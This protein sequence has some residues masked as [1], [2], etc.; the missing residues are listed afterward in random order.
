M[1]GC[2]VVTKYTIGKLSKRESLG[3]G[4]GGSI[5]KIW[6]FKNF[7]F[8]WYSLPFIMLVVVSLHS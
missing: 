5:M 8:L 7:Y 2:K 3:G 4:G 6:T 1:G